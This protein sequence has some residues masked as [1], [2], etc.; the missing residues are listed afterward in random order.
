RCSRTHD[1]CQNIAGQCADAGLCS[2]TSELCPPSVCPT[3]QGHC[4]IRTTTA[5]FDTSQC[6]DT[7]TCAGAPG[8]Q[9]SAAGD[10]PDIA[11]ACN[12]DNIACQ[13]TGD[14]GNAGHCSIQTAMV[15]H[16]AGECPIVPGT[17]SILHN[18]CVD[19]T[20]PC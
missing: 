3:L 5:C 9:C 11:G 19:G 8:T 15:C 13:V 17:C 2:L 16:A 18:S 7:G 10:C 12:I 1:S 4:S 20:N 14:C 6:L